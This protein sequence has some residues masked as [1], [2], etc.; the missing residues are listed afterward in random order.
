DCKRRVPPV[1]GQHRNRFG[2]HD[3]S[4]KVPVDIV[5]IAQGYGEPV[6]LMIV[7]STKQ[8]I[9]RRFHQR[10]NI[11][12][13]DFEIRYSSGIASGKSAQGSAP[14]LSMANRFGV[15]A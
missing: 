2:M 9:A 14:Q 8:W 7:I 11:W 6:V 15:T 5:H 3:R 4:R 13:V 10:A 12:I 1:H